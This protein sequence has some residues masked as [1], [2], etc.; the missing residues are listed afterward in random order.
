VCA[1]LDLIRGVVEGDPDAA[2]RFVDR[3]SRFVWGIL[4]RDLKL[5]PGRAEELFQRVFV[6][7]WDRDCHALRRWRGAGRFVSYLGPIVRHL[8][9]DRWKEDE[10]DRT[11][12]L[13]DE[14]GAAAYEVVD[15]A[16]SPEELAALEEQRAALWRAVDRLP[17]RDA[18]VMRLRIQSDRSYA[19]IAAAMGISSNLVGV[20]LYRS[21]QELARLVRKELER[22]ALRSVQG[23]VRSPDPG[24]SRR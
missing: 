17:A 21:N 15:D 1:D 8:A 24:A 22:P 4:A 19:E 11:E 20:I 9:L 7:L 2:R 16:P 14:R 23:G 12:S 6:R 18:E 5:D 13:E 10:R 3:F